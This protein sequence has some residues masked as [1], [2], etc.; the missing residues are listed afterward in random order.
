MVFVSPSAL[1]GASMEASRRVVG[2]RVMCLWGRVAMTA[3]TIIVVGIR[4]KDI[5]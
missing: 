3:I 2:Q 1:I 5:S 4:V